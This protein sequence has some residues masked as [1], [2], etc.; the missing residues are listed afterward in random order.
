LPQADNNS[1]SNIVI[2]WYPITRDDLARLKEDMEGAVTEVVISNIRARK[3]LDV[4]FVL[5]AL[6]AS[7]IYL[8]FPNNSAISFLPLMK[9]LG[10]IVRTRQRFIVFP[11]LGPCSRCQ[12]SR[13]SDGCAWRC[14]GRISHAC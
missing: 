6:P 8:V 5:R 9:I 11:D 12:N 13:F 14:P 10:L 2:S 4:L 3:Y 1:A 7:A